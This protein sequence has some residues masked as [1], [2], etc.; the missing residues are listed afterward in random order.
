MNKLD[1][2][3]TIK[4][5]DEKGVLSSIKLLPK[6]A[7]QAWVEVSKL[8]LPKSFAN[9]KNIVVCGMGG[10][11]LGER[12]IDSFTDKYIRAPMEIFTQYYIP[13]YVNNDSLVIISSYSGN[14]EE[15]LSCAHLALERN[16]CVFV[17]TTGGK[18]AELVKNEEL[19][20]YVYDP[21]HNPGKQPRL[22]LGYSIFSILALLNKTNFIT[23]PTE[24]FNDINKCLG[25]FIDE[26][27]PRTP[28]IKNM[29]KILA[30]GIQRKIPL[31]VASEHLSGTA[32]TFKNQLNETSKTF[33]TFFEIP[34]LNHH[35][36]EGLRFPA[37]A[38]EILHF[39]F[40]KSE[41]YSERV[42]RR[43]PLTAEVIEKNSISQDCY[44]V[45]SGTKMEQVVEI[46]ALGTFVSFY[47]A[48]LNNVDPAEIPWV[49]YFKKKLS[50]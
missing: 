50:D 31:I 3:E 37:K 11:A 16:A 40:L 38:K 26:F 5:F 43:Y 12:V 36:T 13:G 6:Q 8:K 24:R 19:M 21:K 7:E 25:K 48:V 32:Y 34:E 29:A 2:L 9:T 14:T 41:L 22:A 18:L 20:A 46:L 42:L 44:V 39:L 27:G 35:L 28:E 15:A 4:K 1:S 49:D 17:I 10:S 33:S 30:N 47:L 45:R 23:L